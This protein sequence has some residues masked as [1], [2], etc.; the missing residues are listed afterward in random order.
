MRIVGIIPAR[1]ASTRLPGKPLLPIAGRPMIQHTYEQ[2]SKAKSLGLLVVAT[3]DP[4][5]KAAVEGFGGLASLTSP[6]HPSGTDRV[7]E[8][9]EDLDCDLVVNI[10]G[11]E[12]FIPPALIDEAIEPFFQDAGLQMGTVCRRILDPEEA[13]DPN[14][15]KVVFDLQGFALYFSRAPIPYYRYQG[16]GVRRQ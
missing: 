12:P 6:H 11:D 7:A 16:S 10:Q 4:R 9:A 13:K 15:V 2:A 3:D 5:V 14:V 1:Y 8:V